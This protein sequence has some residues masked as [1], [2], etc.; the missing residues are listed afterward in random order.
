MIYNALASVESLPKVEVKWY[1]TSSEGKQEH[2]FSTILTDAII[3]DMD[4]SMMKRM[5]ELEEEN[6]RLK[7]MC[8]QGIN[9]PRNA[10]KPRLF[11]RH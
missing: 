5:K 8:P 10:S 6:R 4:V 9:M 7:M 1:R 11:R 2:F 3:V